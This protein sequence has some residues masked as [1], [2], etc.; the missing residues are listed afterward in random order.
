MQ[1]SKADEFDDEFARYRE[2]LSDEVYR[3]CSCVKVY[4]SIQTHKV[5]HLE[6]LNLAPAFFQITETHF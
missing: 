1:T 5:D 6:K 2:N 3:F 4:R